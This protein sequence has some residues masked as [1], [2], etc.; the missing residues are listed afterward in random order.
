MIRANKWQ[1]VAVHCVGR[2][3]LGEAGV[4]GYLSGIFWKLCPLA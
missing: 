1:D 3:F 4:Q 2:W